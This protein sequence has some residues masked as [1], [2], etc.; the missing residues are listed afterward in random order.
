MRLLP[1]VSRRWFRAR[2]NA[3]PA[4]RMKRPKTTNRRRRTIRLSQ[5]IKLCY[6]YSRNTRKLALITYIRVDHN[7]TTSSPRSFFFHT[8]IR[9][10]D[11]SH[12]QMRT[13]TRSGHDRGYPLVRKRTFL[14][15]RWI[16]T[17]EVPRNQ[18]HRELTGGVRTDLA[19][20]GVSEEI[21]SDETVLQVQ[22]RRRQVNLSRYKTAS[23]F[24]ITDRVFTSIVL[25]IG[26]CTRD[27]IYCNQWH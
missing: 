12:V 2:W 19:V 18:R 15:D 17:A 21:P 13:N 10:S 25:F 4:N 23:V 22:L 9:I 24:D 16:Y 5:T 8:A 20:A 7:P 11:K 14:R 6:V 27:D 3:T 1:R 26:K